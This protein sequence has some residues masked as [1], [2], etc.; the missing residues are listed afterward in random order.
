[1]MRDILWVVGDGARQGLVRDAALTW[2]SQRKSFSVYQAEKATPSAG[3]LA[4]VNSRIC[5]AT[6]MATPT[7]ALLISNLNDFQTWAT[8]SSSTT[9][10][11]SWRSTR[12]PLV[13]LSASESD[14]VASPPPHTKQ[15]ICASLQTNGVLLK[16]HPLPS[17]S[18]DCTAAVAFSKE[19][20]FRNRSKHFALR[21]SF[22]SEQQ[23]PSV[24][25]IQ[26]ISVSRKI[27]LEC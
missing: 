18:E 12:T 16:P 6:S 9:A 23:R 21:W 20:C 17:R 19:N 3:A 25:D 14:V 1:M 24:G 10:L 15:F 4:L 5:L 7:R 8:F 2:R 27:M 26:I 11:V 13:T 22:V